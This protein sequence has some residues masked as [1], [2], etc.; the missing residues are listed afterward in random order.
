MLLVIINSAHP[1][2]SEVYEKLFLESDEEESD[3]EKIDRLLGA[4][5]AFKLSLLAWARME[6]ESPARAQQFRDTRAD[7]GRIL[8]HF[9]GNPSELEE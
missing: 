6:D 4:Q 8:R 1:F 2:Y 5:D 7:W 9:L 3:Q